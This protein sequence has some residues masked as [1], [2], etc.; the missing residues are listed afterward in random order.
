MGNNQQLARE[1]VQSLFDDPFSAPQVVAK[2]WAEQ[3]MKHR[4]K[5][6]T[7][8]NHRFASYE[9]AVDPARPNSLRNGDHIFVLRAGG[10]YPHHGL[11]FSKSDAGTVVP[12][13]IHLCPNAGAPS[14]ANTMFPRIQKT[15]L[16][17]FRGTS[18]WSDIGVMTYRNQDLMGRSREQLVGN[19]HP[20]G[21]YAQERLPVSEIEALAKH[22]L[23]QEDTNRHYS[24][25]KFNCEHFA[26]FCCLGHEGFGSQQIHFLNGL[27]DQ[28]PKLIEWG[29]NEFSHELASKQRFVRDAVHIGG[30]A[31]AMFNPVTLQRFQPVLEALY[32]YLGGDDSDDELDVADETSSNAGVS[33]DPDLLQDITARIR[34]LLG[35]S[36]AVRSTCWATPLINCEIT[37]SDV[38]EKRK[39][40]LDHNHNCLK[41]EIPLYGYLATLLPSGLQQDTPTSGGEGGN[42]NNS[43]ADRHGK[44]SIKV[45]TIQLSQEH[46]DLLLQSIPLADGLS[47]Q[48]IK[49]DGVQLRFEWVPR[50]QSESTRGNSGS[51]DDEAEP[52]GNHGATQRT[53]TFAEE[54]SQVRMLRVRLC[55]PE[56]QIVMKQARP[57]AVFQLGWA[58]KEDSEEDDTFFS[59]DIL[60]VSTFGS[61]GE[62]GVNGTTR[63]AFAEDTGR[64]VLKSPSEMTLLNRNAVVT[65]FGNR[66]LSAK[67]ET[68]MSSVNR[69]LSQK[70]YSWIATLNA[71]CESLG[72]WSLLRRS[73]YGHSTPTII[74][75]DGSS[76]RAHHSTSDGARAFSS[77]SDVEGSEY[78]DENRLSAA[79]P[80]LDLGQMEREE[81]LLKRG[82]C[83]QRL[84]GLVPESRATE[85]AEAVK[86]T[87]VDPPD[88]KSAR[89]ACSSCKQFTTGRVAFEL[90]SHLRVCGVCGC[91]GCGKQ[92]EG[93]PDEAVIA[94]GKAVFPH[95]S[96][97]E[98]VDMLILLCQ[99]CGQ[100][101]TSTKLCVC[102]G[103]ANRTTTGVTVN[104]AG[105]CQD[106]DSPTKRLP[107]AQAKRREACTVHSAQSPTTKSANISVDHDAGPTAETNHRK[108][109]VPAAL[110][111]EHTHSPPKALEMLEETF[112]HACSEALR[113]VQHSYSA[114]CHLL[115]RALDQLGRGCV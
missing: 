105:Y 107:P 3:A 110:Q 6:F 68:V 16:D 53:L 71:I 112:L 12:Y 4:P 17:Y 5:C 58:D 85:L 38:D 34:A 28:L 51:N 40:R 62:F 108:V 90:G 49:A 9:D 32:D 106:C 99:D 64:C 70:A 81:K 7:Q 26:Q 94:R 24:L 25:Y 21:T 98:L 66:E 91:F 92:F 100:L 102:C 19:A 47:I 111:S 57:A 63:F 73:A 69:R 18:H 56:L 48:S 44:R 88:A 59:A 1:V 35:S 72:L 22:M 89:R 76:G 87:A 115:Q 79:S 113:P 74:G 96:H 41:F 67:V 42:S 93:V 101:L 8:P 2:R 30:T 29:T 13:V 36:S 82:R 95:D 50:L 39:R 109:A 83:A 23:A 43:E 97:S 20:A 61:G 11:F 103:R 55:A 104:A 31:L 114:R 78:R 84:R 45:S 46:V 77:D 27:I 86:R 60:M 54:D 33:S 52:K 65:A 15:S 75:N 10:L 14:W 80:R 37:A